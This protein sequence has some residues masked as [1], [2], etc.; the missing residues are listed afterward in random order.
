MEKGDG[1]GASSVGVA[2]RVPGRWSRATA[3]ALAI[4]LVG[5]TLRIVGYLAR[6][7][8][9]IDDARLGTN[10]GGRSFLDL[11]RPLDY[12]QAAPI[13]LLWAD[14][15]MTHLAGVNEFTLRAIPL[16]CGI[17]LLVLL[18]R[19]GRE[20]VGE[21][22]ALLATAIAAAAPLFL[23]YSAYSVKQYGVDAFV[24][25]ALLTLTVPVIGIPPSPAP[26]EGS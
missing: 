24:T 16:V 7:S 6:W 26:G 10:V 12:E 11:T 18:W 17:G 9:F 25:I 22:E 4:I 21:R 13:L 19:G 15:L 23:Q 8:L 2:E 14:R 3:I 20:L 1:S 5:A